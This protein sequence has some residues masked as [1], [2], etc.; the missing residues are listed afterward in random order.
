MLPATMRFFDAHCD[1]I[2]KIL[3][4]K[5]DFAGDGRIGSS[6][7]GDGAG[8]DADA[9]SYQPG[10]DALHITLPGLR[11]AGVCVQVFASWAWTGKYKGREFEVGMEKVEAVRRMCDQYPDDLFLALTGTEIAAACE[12][13]GTSAS[14]E[15]DGPD[16]GQKRTAVIASLEGADPLLGDVDNL[17]PFYDAGVRLITLAWADNAFVGSG[18]ESGRGLTA[19]GVDLVAAC[20]DRRVITKRSSTYSE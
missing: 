10:G 1:T 18:Y 13:L 7:D 20:E 6:D 19:K 17:R 3:E 8:S 12:V 2:G 9:R 14:S 4:G 11:A 15:L 5:A 16:A